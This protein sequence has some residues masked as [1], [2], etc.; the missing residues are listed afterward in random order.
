MNKIR[1]TVEGNPFGKERPRHNG[2]T[3]YTPTKTKQH[4]RTVA[5]EYRKQCGS[6][7]FSKDEYID[8]RIIAYMPIPKSV[9]KKVRFMM[10]S[11][12]VRPTVKP[13]WDNIG[14]LITD[15]LNDVA[16]DDDKAITDAQVRK[17][18][19]DHPRTE[20]VIYGYTADEKKT[21]VEL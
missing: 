15:A 12:I 19:S 6:F 16:Y 14:K 2:Y 8:I 17:F 13:D 9:S 20:I 21:E 10:L 18:Y 1:F 5:M 4:E 3:T 7:R 11:G